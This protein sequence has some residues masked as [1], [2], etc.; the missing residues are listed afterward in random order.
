MEG[1]P[2]IAAYLQTRYWVDGHDE[3]ILIGACNPQLDQ[4]LQKQGLSTWAY[5]TAW[6]PLSQMHLD[7]ENHRRNTQLLKE[8]TG[9]LVLKGKGEGQNGD[10]P[11]EES[12]LV[13]GISRQ[14]A[15]QLGRLHG[16]RAIVFGGIGKPAELVITVPF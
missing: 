14:E 16:Q 6:N 3:P 7:L 1:N 13:L 8:L 11:P 10:W 15:E 12:F 4:L 9:F 5:I 2:V